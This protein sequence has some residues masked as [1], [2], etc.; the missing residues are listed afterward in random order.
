MKQ[1]TKIVI[2][3]GGFGG[4]YTYFSLKKQFNCDEIDVT[5]I[6]ST[7]YFLFTPMLHEVATGGLAHHQIVESIRE[8]IY[9]SHAKLY[10]AKVESVDF[11]AKV[12]ETTLGNLSYDILVM[13]LG[14]TTNYFNTPGAKENTFTLKNLSDAISMRANFIDAF[15]SASSMLSSEDRSRELS[16]GVIGGGST[17]VELVAET[18]ELFL[19]TFSKYYKDSINPSEISLYLIN[20]GPEILMP[21][22]KSLRTH[23]LE[24]LK[25]K[26]VKV[27]LNSGVKEVKENGVILDDGKFLSIKHMVWTAGVT[28][29]I[30]ILK[31]P[32]PLDKTGRIV[33]NEYLQIEKYPNVFAIGDIASVILGGD[34]PLP[35]LAQIAVK[36]GSLV[37]ENIKN[38]IL[39][40]KLKKFSYTSS[41]E[42]ISLGHWQGVANIKGVKFSGPVAWFIWRTVYLFKFLSNS[43]KFK[44]AADWTLNVFYPRDITKS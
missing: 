21:F 42:L 10:V 3:G 26:G 38:F 17:G 35:M 19:K 37:G 16:F 32:A 9:K 34:R 27:L 7:N 41:G 31:N 29:N 30:P 5:I 20:R 24:I 22:E 40:K 8:V 18:A 25:K 15:E 39:N 12:V 4:L 1:K 6:N 2:L 44:I 43:K 36:Q 13:A 23:A 11:E 28:P 33:V 14:S